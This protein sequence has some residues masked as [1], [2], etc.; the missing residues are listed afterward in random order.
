MVLELAVGFWFDAII[1]VGAVEP[2]WWLNVAQSLWLLAPAYYF[3]FRV[4]RYRPV[5]QRGPARW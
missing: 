3:N 5:E 1:P 2:E 4:A